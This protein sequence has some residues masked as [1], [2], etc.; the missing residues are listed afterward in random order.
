M[1]EGGRTENKGKWKIER[2]KIL[3]KREKYCIYHTG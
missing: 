2:Y 1:G 3:L